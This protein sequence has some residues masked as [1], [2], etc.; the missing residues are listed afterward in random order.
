MTMPLDQ[1]VPDVNV[2]FTQLD[3]EEVVL[4][5]LI[6]KRYYTLNETGT[7]IWNLFAEGTSPADMATA[8]HDAYDISEVE[9]MQYV[10]TLLEELKQEGLVEERTVS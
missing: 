10:Q 5:H 1:W 4:L 6:T 7:Y 9:A 2:V 3:E 8:I